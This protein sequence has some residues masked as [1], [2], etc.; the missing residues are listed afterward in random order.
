MI[1]IPLKVKLANYQ[2]ASSH[3]QIKPVILI[4]VK[5]AKKKTLFTMAKI[6]SSVISRNLHFGD[7]QI[8]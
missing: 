6:R 3:S 1:V 5:S 8:N 2:K 4:I 7:L